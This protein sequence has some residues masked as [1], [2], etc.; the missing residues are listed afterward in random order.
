MIPWSE[1]RWLNPPPGVRPDGDDLLVTA[2]EG[3]DFWR[4]TG[5]GFVHDDGHALLAG[6]PPGSALEVAFALDYTEQFDQA[7]LLVRVDERNW[8]KAGVEH[9]DGAP[10]LG[11]VVTRDHSDWSLA[12]VPE[13][14]GREVTIRASRSGDAVTFRAR[15]ADGPWRMFRLAPLAPDAAAT[16]GPY[17]CAPTRAGL[18]VRFTSLTATA[19]DQSL[20]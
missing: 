17:V 20:H 5:Y 7:G 1:G 10:Q 13:W 6:F 16:A 4:T 18:T 15:V 2:A 11:A 14:A 19:P 12:P 9:S 3:S 8:V